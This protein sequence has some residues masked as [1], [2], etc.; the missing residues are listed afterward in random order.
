MLHQDCGDISNH[1]V[2]EIKAACVQLG[3]SPISS[4][5]LTP[6]LQP[7]KLTLPNLCG[8]MVHHCLW[9]RGL[10]KKDSWGFCRSQGFIWN[11][12]FWGTG[13]NLTISS[14]FHVL[15]YNPWPSAARALLLELFSL[16]ATGLQGSN[17]GRLKSVFLFRSLI[18]QG[19]YH[20]SAN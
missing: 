10:A 7:Q 6:S 17:S 18:W 11:L 12:N 3:F 2:L 15:F 4:V 5:P 19:S 13:F 1:F 16:Q 8:W 9:F 20:P 14:K